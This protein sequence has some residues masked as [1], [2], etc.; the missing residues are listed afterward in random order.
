MSA[1]VMYMSNS[2]YTM[3]ILNEKEV[4]KVFAEYHNLYVFVPACE[5]AGLEVCV[6]A[7]SFYDALQIAKKEFNLVGEYYNLC[8]MMPLQKGVLKVR[9][10]YFYDEETDKW[11]NE[12]EYI[13]LL[14][15]RGKNAK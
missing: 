13:K 2:Q 15:R 10:V 14:E 5:I 8:L 6:V 4:G 12:D 11:Y 9:L 3:T 7:R 1:D